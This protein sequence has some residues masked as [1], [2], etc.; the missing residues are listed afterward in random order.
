MPAERDHALVHAGAQQRLCGAGLHAQVL[1]ALNVLL[2]S[3][4]VLVDLLEMHVDL[5]ED[6]LRDLVQRSTGSWICD[7]FVASPLLRDVSIGP[8]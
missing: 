3:L 7:D 1:G 6:V 2:E 5:V 8:A 4:E